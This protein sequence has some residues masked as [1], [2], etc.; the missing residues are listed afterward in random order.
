VVTFGKDPTGAAHGGY[1]AY[2]QSLVFDDATCN[3]LPSGMAIN[4]SSDGG[5]TWTNAL[6]VEADAGAGLNDKNW[7]VTDNAASAT[8]GCPTVTPCHHPGRTYIVW[9]RV[10]SIVFAYCDPDSPVSGTMGTGCDKITNWSSVTGKAFFPLFPLQ[11]IGTFPIVL[12]NGS[13]AIIYDSRTSTCN[14]NEQPNC[15][16]GGS[17][18]NWGVIPGM[19]GPIWPGPPPP[20]TFAPVPVAQYATVREQFQRAGGLPQLAY[21]P[22]TGDAVVAWEDNRYRNDGGAIP[23][24]SDTSLQNDAVISFSTPVAGVPGATWSAPIRVNQG[25][26]GDFMNHWNTMVAV[27]AD[28]IWR[29]GYR[30]RQEPAAGFTTATMMSPFIDTYYQE[31]SDQGT[32]WTAPLKV[33]TSIATDPQFGAFSRFSNVP[34]LGLFLG[35]YQQLA[36]GGNDETYVTRDEAFAPTPGAT[37]NTGFSTPMTCQNQTTWVAHLLPQSSPNIPDTRFIPAIVLV[38]GAIGVIALRRRRR[39]DLET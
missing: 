21:D 16:V 33:N 26:M 39:P 2:A 34:P 22:V 15:T 30:T 35:D 20:F 37:C 4:V 1:F 38:G 32:T 19:G 11:A 5:L 6:M 12:N 29:V 24:L 14:P 3:G 17:N 18:I 13:L 36:A 31:S 25:S 10:A 23:G 9:D 8:A 27:G 28:G 7:I